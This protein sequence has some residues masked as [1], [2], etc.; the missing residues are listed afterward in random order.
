[1]RILHAIIIFVIFVSIFENIAVDCKKVSKD[2]KKIRKSKN[3]VEKKMEI[4]AT[5]IE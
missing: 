4:V 2:V 3:K 1:M 5:D